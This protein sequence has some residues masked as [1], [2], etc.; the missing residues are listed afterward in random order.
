MSLDREQQ[1]AI[2]SYDF[3]YLQC[4]DTGHLWLP[5]SVLPPRRMKKGGTT[6]KLYER[7]LQC[8]RCGMVR[9]DRYFMGQVSHSYDQ[10]DDY[11]LPGVRRGTWELREEVWERILKAGFKGTG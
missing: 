11:K 9:I 7:T 2:R 3:E 4:R 10:P 6:G 5:S 1:Q 8:S